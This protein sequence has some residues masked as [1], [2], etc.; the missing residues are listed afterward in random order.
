MGSASAQKAAGAVLTADRNPNP[1]ILMGNVANMCAVA[2]EGWVPGTLPNKDSMVTRLDP[3][4]QFQEGTL[5]HC[6]NNVSFPCA[7]EFPPC[8]ANFS[9]MAL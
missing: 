7:T 8:S 2:F 1:P 6:S 4:R 5:Q 9:L 3:G